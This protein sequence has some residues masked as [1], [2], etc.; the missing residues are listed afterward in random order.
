MV[1]PVGSDGEPLLRVGVGVERFSSTLFGAAVD[2]AAGLAT[3]D[4]R[5]HGAAI[6]TIG[7]G[8]MVA[9]IAAGFGAAGAGLSG[10]ARA[11]I[12]CAIAGFIGRTHGGNHTVE[13]DIAIVSIATGPHRTSSPAVPAV[14]K[15]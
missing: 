9:V 13:A 6:R 2:G 11:G 10:V 15:I 5:N 7:T 8:H 1:A 14:I 3:A 4:S 12:R